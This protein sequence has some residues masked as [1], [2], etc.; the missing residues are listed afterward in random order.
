MLMTSL[1][2]G[3]VMSDSKATAA[4]VARLNG[5]VDA[6]Q[7][8]LDAEKHAPSS[9]AMTLPRALFPKLKALLELAASLPEEQAKIE[10]LTGQLDKIEISK[11]S[12]KS[13]RKELDAK[14][15]QTYNDIQTSIEEVRI[16]SA[17]LTQIE[18]EIEVLKGEVKA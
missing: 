4:N 10:S 2:T 3:V 16:A 15:L 12:G 17:K 5:L 6:A 1:A 8:A 9:K 7:A 14:V 11:R 18:R 13:E